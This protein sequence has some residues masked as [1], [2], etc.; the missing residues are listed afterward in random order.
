MKYKYELYFIIILLLVLFIIY[1]TYTKS[2]KI[3]IGIYGSVS[4]D[5]SNDFTIQKD[6][7][8]LAHNLDKSKLFI[9]PNN[10]NGLIGFLL[11]NIQCKQNIITTYSN[12]F[13]QKDINNDFYVKILD[14]PIDYEEY[15]MMNS[16]HFVFLPGGV[17][18]LY[19][20]SFVLLL[21]DVSSDNFK[22][23]FYNKDNYFNF[24]KDKMAYFSNKGYLRNNVYNKFLNNSYFF[25]DI[26]ELVYKLNN[27]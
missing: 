3:T 6:L 8:Y 17:G 13:E 23:L 26:K 4:K 10:K 5:I 27:I 20:I 16:D 2:Y 14:N 21:L 1:T 25:T 11:H 24:V 9:I 18:T 12:T 7:K 15:M 19:E 22:I